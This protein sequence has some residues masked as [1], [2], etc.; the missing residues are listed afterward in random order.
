[1]SILPE[2]LGAG[3]GENRHITASTV[4]DVINAGRVAMGEPALS[5]SDYLALLNPGPSA[6]LPE[7]TQFHIPLDITPTLP[8]A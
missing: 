2:L 3:A 6:T 7:A 8:E 4:L 5:A 1:M